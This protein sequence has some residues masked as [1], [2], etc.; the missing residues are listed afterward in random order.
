M[1]VVPLELYIRLALV[2]LQLEKKPSLPKGSTCHVRVESIIDCLKFLRECF[3][4]MYF[5]V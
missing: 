5:I 1:R 3:Y 2:D 4:C